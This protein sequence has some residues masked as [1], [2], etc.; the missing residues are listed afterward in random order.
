LFFE[1]RGQRLVERGFGKE[2]LRRQAVVG[3]VAVEREAG[4]VKHRAV[5]RRMAREQG[6]VVG[7]QRGEAAGER[8]GVAPGFVVD[9][10]DAHE[11]QNLFGAA[12]GDG[13]A[14]GGGGAAGG[15]DAGG[16]FATL[17]AAGPDVGETCVEA[18]AGVGRGARLDL[19]KRGGGHGLV[20]FGDARIVVD[21]GEVGVD[22][23]G[24]IGRTQGDDD[25]IVGA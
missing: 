14:V 18:Q 3:G 13:R 23:G 16:G 6:V 25:D 10:G 1:E 5:Q 2:C 21:K 22:H 8:G 24:A 9:Y 19:A 12:H 11:H 20:A 4:A 15:D 17:R 7:G